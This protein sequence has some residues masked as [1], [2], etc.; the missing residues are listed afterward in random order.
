MKGCLSCS[1]TDWSIDAPAIS[2]PSDNVVRG[3]SLT[4]KCTTERNAM[5][6]GTRYCVELDAL[7]EVD[8]K[9][10]TASCGQLFSNMRLLLVDKIVS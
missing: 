9:P 7:I 2:L 1:I 5:M 6:N 4:A 10:A 8:R 3:A